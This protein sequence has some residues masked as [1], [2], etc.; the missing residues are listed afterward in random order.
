[1]IFAYDN[2]GIVGLFFC[3]PKETIER[4][5]GPLTEEQYLEIV[6]QGIPETAIRLPDD[7]TSPD[8]SRRDEWR[9][10]NGTVIIP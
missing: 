10:V 3:T 9:I 5:T 8:R 4:Q 1:M 6:M 7:W 2:N